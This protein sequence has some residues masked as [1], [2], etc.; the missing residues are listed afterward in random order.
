MER[1]TATAADTETATESRGKTRVR[2]DIFS[3]PYPAHPAL[4]GAK[5][6]DEAVLGCDDGRVG[7]VIGELIFLAKSRK[8]DVGSHLRPSAMHTH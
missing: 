3:R 1:E 2:T 5:R 7:D 4:D 6:L 8:V